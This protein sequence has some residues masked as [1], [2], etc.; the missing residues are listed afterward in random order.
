MPIGSK[1]DYEK[2]KGIYEH[3]IKKPVEGAGL[4]LNCIRADEVSESGAIIKDIVKRLYE[5]DIVIADLSTLNANVCYELGVRHTLKGGTIMIT[6][7]IK[8]IPF[9]LKTYRVL[10]Y[11]RDI[12]EAEDFKQNLKKFLIAVLED[13]RSKDNPVLDYL[14][15][16]GKERVEQAEAIHNRQLIDE[17]KS[18][19]AGKTKLLEEEM[20]SLRQERA[21]IA[22]LPSDIQ[23][24]ITSDLKEVIKV[25]TNRIDNLEKKTTE[26]EKEPEIEEE[27]TVNQLTE[28]GNAAYVLG[29]YRKAIGA[30]SKTIE[31]KPKNHLMYSN[32]AM[33][34]GRL[35]DEKK[36][37]ADYSKAVELNPRSV[38]TY[39]NRGKL[40]SDMTEFEK[41]I[42]DFSKCID[43]DPKYLQAY[44]YRGIVYYRMREFEKAIADYQKSIELGPKIPNSYSNLGY[45]LYDLDRVEEAIEQWEKSVKLTTLADN[46]SGLGLGLW[47]IGE[48]ERGVQEY[49]KALELDER[50]AD[51]SWLPIG[52]FWSAKAIADAKPLIKEVK[53]KLAELKR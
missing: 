39:F 35:K 41:A 45:V 31:L 43:L 14:P 34:Y 32:R 30:Y 5:A 24:E 48:N 3:L 28:D 37:I 44:D 6:D 51:I 29:K 20:K 18:E 23:K 49:R 12:V 46:L 26:L 7:D 19:L 33:A 11:S 36:A 21:R 4:E 52:P 22:P 16:P 27:K 10:Q 53:N 38:Y 17:L 42:A 40:Y 50:Y 9:D 25:M 2:Y 47:K 8:T 1:E 15:H 13:P